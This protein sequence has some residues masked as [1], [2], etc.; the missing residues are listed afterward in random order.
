M[1]ISHDPNE[2]SG[3]RTMVFSRSR[4]DTSSPGSITHE[5]LESA[6]GGF[7]SASYRCRSAEP[8]ARRDASVE[9][10]AACSAVAPTPTIRQ[11]QVI[12]SFMRD[13][14]LSYPFVTV[15][16]L[17]ASAGAV[18]AF[19]AMLTR[20]ALMRLGRKNRLSRDVDVATSRIFNSVVDLE[21]RLGTQ[22]SS[23]ESSLRKE[24]VELRR[25]LS[26]SSGH[27]LGHSLST[28]QER[29]SSLP[30]HTQLRLAALPASSTYW[31]QLH[32]NLRGLRES[33]THL[34]DTVESNTAVCTASERN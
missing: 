1:S 26:I 21:R 22:L 29:L 5:A 13:F 11:S 17:G 23:N 14:A 6:D 32:L 33:V 10:S 12:P 16:A 18:F 28:R 9:A 4:G 3:Q 20:T 19:S 34:T 15:A 24:I 25:L 27:S 7:C 2:G 8:A 30:D 31:D